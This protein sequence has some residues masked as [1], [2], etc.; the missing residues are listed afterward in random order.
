M[1]LLFAMKAVFLWSVHP[2]AIGTATAVE[3]STWCGGG[4]AIANK[5]TAAVMLDVVES[6]Q[7]ACLG[8]FLCGVV[9]EGGCTP[10]AILPSYRWVYA[11][12]A[13]VFVVIQFPF[14][15]C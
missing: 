8:C 11:A 6:L 14:S 15:Q 9:V 2:I 5:L 3:S 13:T 7:C 10:L 1:V 12:V 4:R